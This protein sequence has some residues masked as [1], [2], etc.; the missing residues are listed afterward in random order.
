M[1]STFF[2]R[3]KFPSVRL[4]GLVLPASPTFSPKPSSAAAPTSDS[5]GR[6]RHASSAVGG[7]MALAARRL[8]AAL[9]DEGV[10]SAWRGRERA[11]R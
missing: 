6:C 8:V 1:T 7:A 10:A 9:G 4:A 11:A 3:F 5:R 2:P